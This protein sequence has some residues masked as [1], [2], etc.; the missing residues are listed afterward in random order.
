MD[1]ETMKKPEK[2]N[3]NF[4]SG[5]PYCSACGKSERFCKCA[6]YDQCWDDREKWLPS[7]GEILGIINSFGVGLS[8]QKDIDVT[9]KIVEVISLR[10]RGEK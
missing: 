6:G 10:L 5:L 9:R 1:K 3:G 4:D 8:S 2:K 7:K